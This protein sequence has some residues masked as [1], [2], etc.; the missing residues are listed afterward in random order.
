MKALDIATIVLAHS[1]NTGDLVTNKK[2][3]KLLYYIEAWSQAYDMSLIDDNFEAWVHGPVVPAVYHEYKR[4]GYAPIVTSYAPGESSSQRLGKLLSSPDLT[5]EQKDILFAVLEQYSP[6]SS[7]QLEQL[8]HK[9]QPWIE[10]REGC[11]PVD[12]CSESISKDTMRRFY[13]SL[14]NVEA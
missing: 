7:Y 14:L 11:G 2:L 12:H 6:M 4:F 5:S 1:D 10:A 13:K 9:E 3:Q 8:S